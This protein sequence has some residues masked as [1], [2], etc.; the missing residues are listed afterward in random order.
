MQ[1][2]FPYSYRGHKIMILCIILI[3][4]MKI[5]NWYTWKYL[6]SSTNCYPNR[7]CDYYLNSI[8]SSA[9]VFGRHRREVLALNNKAIF[10]LIPQTMTLRNK[11]CANYAICDKRRAARMPRSVPLKSYPIH[12]LK[13]AQIFYHISYLL[14]RASLNNAQKDPVITDTLLRV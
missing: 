13:T 9:H 7:Y 14:L 4:N 6:I 12:I 2:P 1:N 10:L 5:T 8:R 3:T 11:F